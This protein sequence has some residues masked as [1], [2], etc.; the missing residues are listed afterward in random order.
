MRKMGK[1]ASGRL[2][3][4]LLI[5]TGIALGGATGCAMT[6]KKLPPVPF[7]KSTWRFGRTDGYHLQTEHYDIYT[8][9]D[10]DI[11]VD[12]LPEFVERAYANYTALVPPTRPL[13]KRMRAFLFV[14]RG[15]W[16]AFTKRVMKE[17]APVYMKIRNGGYSARGVTVMEY[18]AHQIT[19][20]LLAHE[21]WHQYLYHQVNTRIPAWINE[22]LA[23]RCEGQRWGNEGVREFDPWYNPMRRNRLAEAIISDELYSLRRLLRTH[24][25]NEIDHTTEKVLTYYAQLWALV[26]F[27]EEGADGKYA[28]GYRR[29]LDQLD[30]ADVEQYARAAHIWS[31]RG[32][33]NYGEALFR[34]FISEDLD[35][36]EAEYR[37]FLRERFINS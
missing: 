33:F 22:G 10:H 13:D 29:M 23:V 4:L 6:P 25:G 21:G 36:V 20:P 17:Q 28:E 19:F 31:E 37:A 16:A 34:S 15:Q 11:L 12:A 2:A 30:D 32:E 1:K 26:L 9:L 3:G 7:E 5:M 8:T 27:L 14:S 35:T 24:P 18:V